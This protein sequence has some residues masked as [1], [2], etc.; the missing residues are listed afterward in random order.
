[1]PLSFPW[2]EQGSAVSQP[3]HEASH[4]LEK[5]AFLWHAREDRGHKRL[6]VASSLSSVEKVSTGT[7]THTHTTNSLNLFETINSSFPLL[8]PAVGR[9]LKIRKSEVQKAFL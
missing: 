3:P 1:M 2:N 4:R 9:D 7:H 6:P 5:V 8:S